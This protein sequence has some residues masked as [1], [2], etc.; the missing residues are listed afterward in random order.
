[1]KYLKF[2]GILVGTMIVLFLVIALFMPTK[3]YIERTID[4]NA[5]IDLVYNQVAD[6][7]N[8]HE[9]NPWAKQD[10]KAIHSVEGSGIGQVYKWKG[11]TIGEGSLTNV[12]YIENKQIDQDL[13]F[14]SPWESKA[15]NGVKFEPIPNGTKVIWIM[16]GDLDY[17]IGRYMKTMIESQVTKDFDNGLRFLK[18]RC[19]K[20]K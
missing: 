5:P 19:E 10:S 11:D 3:Y 8:Y 1:M 6:L 4:I 18:E 2:I 15:Y 12:K 14:I 13:V 16:E 7:N 17:P 9:W 20:I